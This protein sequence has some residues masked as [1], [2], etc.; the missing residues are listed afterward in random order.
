MLVSLDMSL[1][2]KFHVLYWETSNVSAFP[3]SWMMK[4]RILKSQNRTWLIKLHS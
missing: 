2:L 1:H 3:D 4:K